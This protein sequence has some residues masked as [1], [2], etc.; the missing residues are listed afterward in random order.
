M[1]IDKNKEKMFQIMD[2]LIAKGVGTNLSAQIALAIVQEKQ[3]AVPTQPC[4]MGEC[5]LP[6]CPTCHEIEDDC[7]CNMPSPQP[8]P[9]HLHHCYDNMAKGG[10]CICP[11]PEPKDETIRISR[12]VAE[13]YVKYVD[14]KD[15]PEAITYIRSREFLIDELRN[16]LKEKESK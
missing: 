6:T 7:L 5:D 9:K 3:E 16:A 14:A 1:N 4:P 11:K 15:C 2:E 10:C 8:E 12:K 13:D